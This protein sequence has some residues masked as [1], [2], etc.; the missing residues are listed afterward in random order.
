MAEPNLEDALQIIKA[1][2]PR[3][4]VIFNNQINSAM[5][6]LKKPKKEWSPRFLETNWNPTE[7]MKRWVREEMTKAERARCLILC[8]PT[9]IGK[10]E[11]A[12]H[13]FPSAHMYFR[14]MFNLEKWNPNAKIIIL[15]DIEWEFIP[16]KKTLLTQMGEGTMTDKY[17]HK[18]TIYVDMPA[19]VLCN[20]L[21]DFGKES[22][23]WVENSMIVEITDKLY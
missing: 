16:Q 10:T 21:P 15:D 19:I 14:G 1:G 8:G 11:W 2:A 13:L 7:L 12:R 4:F 17:K 9:R 20:T 6:N 22:A 23:Y 3:D 5:A 18:T